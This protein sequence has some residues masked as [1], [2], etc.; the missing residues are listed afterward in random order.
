MKCGVKGEIA[1]QQARQVR[2]HPQDVKERAPE[3]MRHFV[4]TVH[5]NIN[6]EDLLSI[7]LR[8]RSEFKIIN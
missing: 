6:F 7:S 3:R 5:N 8:Y 1:N 2:A 4:T